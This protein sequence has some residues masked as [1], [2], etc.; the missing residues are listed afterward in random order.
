M[1]QLILAG[2]AATF[3]AC[4][5]QAERLTVPVTGAHLVQVG[6]GRARVQLSMDLPDLEDFAV[7]RA[8]LIADSWTESREPLEVWVR[9]AD[10]QGVVD[11][12]VTSRTELRS[13]PEG[14]VIDVTSVLLAAADGAEPAAMV[15]SLP[16]WQEE[17]L[18]S[19]LA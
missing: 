19:E 15:L 16:A 13:T 10:S 11:P 4:P 9:A 12:Q 6:E 8:T 7:V 2:A 1:R 5:A 17:D 18:P 14:L 3:M